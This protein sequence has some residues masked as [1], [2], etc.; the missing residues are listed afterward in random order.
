MLS[1]NYTSPPATITP[2]H[3]EARRPVAP[4]SP[5]LGRRWLG[6]DDGRAGEEADGGVREARPGRHCSDASRHG[7]QDRPEILGGRPA[8]VGDGA[9]AVVAHPEAP[10]PRPRPG[11]VEVARPAC[12]RAPNASCAA[13]PPT[14]RSRGRS[15]QHQA[16]KW[17]FARAIPRRAAAIGEFA[18]T[19]PG[20]ALRR[21][22]WTKL[23]TSGTWAVKRSTRRP[24][25][26]T[27]AS[28]RSLPGT[29]PPA[30]RP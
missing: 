29:P 16:S 13:R 6:E 30:L 3:P 24:P 18:P 15:R 17:G 20:E 2:P 5:S 21:L 12:P 26:T 19:P 11:E 9:G 7:P 28:R 25:R 4:P 23:A 10:S 14:N 22:A 1:D 8:A 27:R